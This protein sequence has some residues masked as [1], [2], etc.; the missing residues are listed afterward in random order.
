MPFAV[1]AMLNL[2]ND[3]YGLF[4]GRGLGRKCALCAID[5][6]TVVCLVAW[7]FYESEAGVD[8]VMIEI[9]LLFLC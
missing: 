9:S 6:L 5:H 4:S 2:S 3:N 7:P 1:N 8:L